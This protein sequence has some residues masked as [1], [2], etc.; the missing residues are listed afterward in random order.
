M[1]LTVVTM[2]AFA[3]GKINMVNDANHLIVFSSD[4]WLKAADAGLAGLPVPAVMPSGTIILVD[5]YGGADAGSMSLQ[6]TTTINA[7]IPG[8][9][10]PLNFTSPNIAGGVTATFQIQVRESGFA[11]AEAARSS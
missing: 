7:A 6:T 5:L 1:T 11:T 9:F 8:G 10:G 3:Q 4:S 2:A